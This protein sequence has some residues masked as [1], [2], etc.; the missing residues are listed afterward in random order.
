VNI[1]AEMVDGEINSENPLPPRGPFNSAY[2]AEYNEF[3][4]LK[5]ITYTNI[6]VNSPVIK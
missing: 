6:Y 2:E 3:G 1:N 5:N 4:Y